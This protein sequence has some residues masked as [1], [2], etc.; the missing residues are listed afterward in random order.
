MKPI[1]HT[2]TVLFALLMALGGN[3]AHGAVTATLDRDRVSLGDSLRLTI[4]AT[5]DEELDDADLRVLLDDFEIL[6]RSTSSNTSIVNGRLSRT[7]QVIIELAPTRQG[8]LQIPSMRFGKSTT[9]SLPVVVSDAPATHDGDQTVQFEAEVDQRNVYVQG[10]IILT[11]RVQQ[12]VNLEGRGISELKLDKAFVKPLEQRSF[13]RTI[14]GRQWLVDELRYAIFPEQS[15]T[16][17]IPAQVFSGRLDRGRRSFFNPGSG[18]LV[19]RSAEAISINVL[20]KPDSFTADTWLPSR[21]VTVEENWSTSPEQMRVGESATRTIRIQ[22]EGL[23]GAQLPPILFAPADGLKYY[24]DQP[25][26]SEQEIPTGLLGIRQDSAAVVPTRAGTFLIPEIRIPWWDTQ[27]EQVRY[28]VLP[29]REIT[30]TAA[31]PT[32]MVVDAT[33][34]SPAIAT[35]P[36]AAVSTAAPAA[37]QHV[38]T[39]VWQILSAVSTVGWLTTLFYLWRRRDSGSKEPSILLDNT[40]ETDAFKRL[41]AACSKGDAAGARSAVISWATTLKPSTPAL[42]LAQV[43]IQLQ[44]EEFTGELKLL[45][46]RLY[47]P[48]QGNWTGATLADCARR[49]RGQHRKGSTHTTEPLR[50]YPSASS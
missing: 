19:R 47:S 10:Q 33:A 5:E 11:L 24:P 35:T 12:A 7:R 50:L 23:Q 29:E 21:H 13:Q 25:Q 18:E 45:D 27:S 30:V 34:S 3:V 14:D 6:Q 32:N 9:A 17:E 43:A 44:D 40:S 22:G 38:Q 36:G 37:S 26:I 20:P 28:A 31:E 48:D 16:L 49:L 46:A 4:S 8:K 1:S 2:I 42:S 15:G 41:L 39:P